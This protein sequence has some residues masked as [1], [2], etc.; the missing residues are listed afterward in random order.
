MAEN[1]LPQ[2]FDAED[3][4][5]NKVMGILCYLGILVVIPY[6]VC[7]DSKFVKFHMNQGLILLVAGIICSVAS[8]IP[9]LGLFAGVIELGIFVLMIIGILNVVNGQAKELPVIGKFSILK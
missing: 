9:V 3:I 8:F 7:K 6:L 2:Q 4:S 1:N 5:S